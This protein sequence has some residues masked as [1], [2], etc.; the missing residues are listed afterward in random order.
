M[1][2]C[3][4]TFTYAQQNL[5]NDAKAKG[6]KWAADPSDC[7]RYIYCERDSANTDD[8]TNIKAVYYLQC[9]QSSPNKYF[10]DDQCLTTNAHCAEALSLCPKTG[11]QDIKVTFY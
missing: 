7:T 5:C 3:L 2:S 9:D 10:K 1:L 4:L 6:F 8:K 11:Q